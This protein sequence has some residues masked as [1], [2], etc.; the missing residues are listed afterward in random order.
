M[1]DET[2]STENCNDESKET[3]K[4]PVLTKADKVQQA[5]ILKDEGNVFYKQKDYKNAMKKYHQCLMYVKGLFDVPFQGL[6]SQ[7]TSSPDEE[8]LGLKTKAQQIELSC[9]NNLAGMNG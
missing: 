6:F 7:E 3:T 8:T 1:A 4:A 2:Q 9:Y 5:S